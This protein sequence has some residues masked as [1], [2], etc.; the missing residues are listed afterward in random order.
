M[1][2][3]IASNKLLCSLETVSLCGKSMAAGNMG[4]TTMRVSMLHMTV[5]CKIENLYFVLQVKGN[6]PALLVARNRQP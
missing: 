3:Q 2:A 1:R 4:Y 5:W 6:N